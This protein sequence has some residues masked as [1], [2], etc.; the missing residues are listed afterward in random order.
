[1]G[2]NIPF[3]GKTF[4]LDGDFRQTLPVVKKANAAQTVEQCIL[5]SPLCP[6]FTIFHFSGN[7][8]VRE[9]EQE[10]SE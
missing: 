9:N 6:F 10:F 2:N 8:R 5:R 1:M 7:H 4:L 3:G